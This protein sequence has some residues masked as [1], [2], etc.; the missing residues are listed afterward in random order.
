MQPY[1]ALA[2][3]LMARGHDVLLAAPSQFEGLAAE[4]QV[5]YAPLPGEFLEILNTP[6]GKAAVAGGQGF[7]AGFKLLKHVRPLMKTLIDEEWAALQSFAPDV[8]VHHPK[9]LTGPH[10]GERLGIPAILASPLPGFG[11][12][13]SSSRR[14][15]GAPVS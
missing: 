2:Q 8:I 11:R 1:L 6:Q 9:M 5:P 10:L 3:A 13:R 12:G 4:R 15:P 7:S 14:T